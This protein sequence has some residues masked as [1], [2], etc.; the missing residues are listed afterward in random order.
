MCLF[1]GIVRIIQVHYQR[2]EC[3]KGYCPLKKVLR[4]CSKHFWHVKWNWRFFQMHKNYYRCWKRK[5]KE[6]KL[7]HNS[8]FR[9]IV[10]HFLEKF[11]KQDISWNLVRYWNFPKYFMLNQIILIRQCKSWKDVVVR[12]NP[13]LQLY[14]TNISS[15]QFSFT[16]SCFHGFLAKK[17][18]REQNA[19][20]CG[21]MRNPLSPEKYFVKSNTYLFSN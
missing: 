18:L 11:R 14:L 5:K 17:I 7:V 16:Q 9:Q 2:A 15:N 10:R 21:K 20:C 13:K 4:H 6:E 3:Q 12:K 8:A 1:N 19:Q